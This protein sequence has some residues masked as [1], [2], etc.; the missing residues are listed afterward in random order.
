MVGQVKFR[1]QEVGTLS[2][3]RAGRYALKWNVFYGFIDSL[4]L[5]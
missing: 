1:S 2:S 5:R 3:R 4:L